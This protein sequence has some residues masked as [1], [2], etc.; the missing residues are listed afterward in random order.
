MKF[1]LNIKHAHRLNQKKLLLQ[2]VE[3][4]EELQILK[5]NFIKST[6]DLIKNDITNNFN[7]QVKVQ[8]FNFKIYSGDNQIIEIKL[9]RDVNEFL[10][11]YKLNQTL[12]S[13]N[14]DIK[15]LISSIEII[16]FIESNK[17]YY[18]TQIK[19]L[20]KNINQKVSFLTKEQ[21]SVLKQIKENQDKQDIFLQKYISLLL[22]K[23]PYTINIYRPLALKN[24]NEIGSLDVWPYIYSITNTFEKGFKINFIEACNNNQAFRLLTQIQDAKTNRWYYKNNQKPINTPMYFL[25]KILSEKIE[26]Q[27]A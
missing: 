19:E 2:N 4:K 17:E 7:L 16:K 23:P 13:Q 5:N 8:H 11:R 14:N 1:F 21:E 20:F 18:I 22:L 6:I 9:V 15:N 24:P 10:I 3:I 25:T 26:K 12:Y 27:Y